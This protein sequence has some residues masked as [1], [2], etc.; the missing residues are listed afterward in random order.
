M[1]IFAVKLLDEQ[2]KTADLCGYVT[3]TGWRASV[4]L[5]LLSD[6]TMSISWRTRSYGNRS[7]WES[8]VLFTWER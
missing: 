3:G 4:L 2:L 7:V 8:W 6:V 1:G 5:L